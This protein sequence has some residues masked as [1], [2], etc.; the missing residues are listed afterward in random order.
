M[1]RGRSLDKA[2]RFV[3]GWVP[4]AAR[5][6]RFGGDGKKVALPVTDDRSP[7]GPAAGTGLAPDGTDLAAKLIA[8]QG[9]RLKHEISLRKLQIFWAVAQGGSVTRAAKMLSL[10][11]PTVSQQLSSLEGTVGNQL[12]E[13][14][15]NSLALT[16]FGALFLRYAETLL[17]A[18]Q[19]LEDMVLEHG[20]GRQ[21]SVR[22]AGVPSALRALM[23]ATMRALQQS[24]RMV[25]FDLHEGAP[26]EVAEMLY[27]RRI[28]IAL[29]A[30]STIG[31]LAAG[32]AMIPLI[33]DPFVLVV[34]EGLDLS[35]VRDPARD[36]SPEDQD[37]LRRT[38]QFAFGNQHARR[39]QHWF[40]TA[41]P[42]NRIVARARSFEL[43]VEMVRGGIGCCVA[44]ALSAAP[45]AVALS[46]VRLYRLLLPP[47][48]IAA[49]IPAHY[50]RHEPYASMLDVMAEVAAQL[51]QPSL[52]PEPP[53]ISARFAGR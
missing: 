10:S 6:M 33:S 44:P 16:E 17:R 21:H 45:G 20:E 8:R 46:G 23:P 24:G 27:A 3:L 35:Q 18:A 52:A 43:V 5:Q 39:L 36:L 34:P 38:I 50:Q 53:F 31:D 14:G 22:I 11:Q 49:I 51:P 42:G 30:T 1:L 48:D 32:F 26:A 28:N 47:R 9:T 37:L 40:D 13:R 15:S 25:D 19:E 41:I 4:A 7:L 2:Q 29:L 12:F